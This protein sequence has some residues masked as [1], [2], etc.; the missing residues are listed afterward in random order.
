MLISA[1]PIP[2][3]LKQHYLASGI[4]ELYPPQAECLQTGMLE[5]RN[6]LISI[7]TASGKTLI[8][9]MAMHTHIAKKESA[10]ISSRSRRL[11]ARNPMN[12]PTRV[13]GLGSLPGFRSPG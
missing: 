1:L 5:G 11:P 2:E 4:V 12:S 7:P 6:L 9:E 10:S 8:A 3:N 13:S